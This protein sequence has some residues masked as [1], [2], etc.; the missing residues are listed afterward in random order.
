VIA[1]Q[2]DSDDLWSYPIDIIDMPV[3]IGHK[4]KIL[5]NY[6]RTLNNAKEV[7]MRVFQGN[8]KASR[9]TYLHP[10]MLSASAKTGIQFLSEILAYDIG[11]PSGYSR[12]GPIM[13]SLISSN[14]T[15]TTYGL[16]YPTEGIELE[17]F[18]KSFTGLSHGLDPNLW[19]FSTSEHNL[20]NDICRALGYNTSTT[21]NNRN[22]T[23]LTPALALNVGLVDK[24]RK[25]LGRQLFRYQKHNKDK[26][27]CTWQIFASHFLMAT[28]GNSQNDTVFQA[29]DHKTFL[30]MI[31]DN[32]SGFDE[33]LDALASLFWLCYDWEWRTDILK[34]QG[35]QNYELALDEWPKTV[36]DLNLQLGGDRAVLKK[37]KQVIDTVGKCH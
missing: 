3:W 30:V 29:I 13:Q 4:D 11:T 10:R 19:N 31:E 8:S 28:A 23:H 5:R 34:T 25:R 18:E 37:R 17:D 32:P 35:F 6:C 2:R 21:G 12:Q 1:L 20:H 24:V 36:G 27:R 7:I 33:V 22:P 14:D 15:M 16:H 9:D 26:D